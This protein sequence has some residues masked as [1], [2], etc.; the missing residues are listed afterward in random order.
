MTDAAVESLGIT[1][2]HGEQ[3]FRSLGCASCPSPSPQRT[4]VGRPAS[5]Y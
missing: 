2:Q 3:R 1:L 5:W 4:W